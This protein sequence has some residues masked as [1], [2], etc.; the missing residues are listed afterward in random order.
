MRWGELLG[1]S[2][3]AS[4]AKYGGFTDM[5][6]L[7]GVPD[8]TGQTCTL[9]RRFKLRKWHEHEQSGMDVE[10]TVFRTHTLMHP[11]AAT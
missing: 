7:N 3:L 1:A 8:S 4:A 10:E 6:T 11:K 9:S 2:T 5:G